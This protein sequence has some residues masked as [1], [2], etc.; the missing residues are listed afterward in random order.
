MSQTCCRGNKNTSLVLSN[1]S[2]QIMPS[3]R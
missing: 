1:L 2:T 3:M